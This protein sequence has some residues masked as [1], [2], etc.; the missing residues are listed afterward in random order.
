MRKLICS[1]LTC[2][3]IAFGARAQELNCNVVINDQQIQA[4]D[5]T[6][7]KEMKT[8][9]TTFMNTRRWTPDAFTAEERIKCNMI[10]T[11]TQSPS[12]GRYSATVQ[13]QS[14]RPIYGTGYETVL[15]NY[16]DKDWDFEY[17]IAQP[18]DFNENVFTSNLT[19]LLSFYAYMIIGYD[20][21]SF[22]KLGGKPFFTMAQTIANNAQQ[23]GGRGWTAFENNQNRYN[24]LENIMNPLM[25]P[26]REGIYTYHR[27]GLDVFAK[28]PEKL[29]ES[30]LELLTKIKA[31]RAQRPMSVLINSFF[32]TKANEMISIYA[33]AEPQQKQ[34]AVNLL[35][36]LDPTKTDQYQKIMK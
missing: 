26:F 21:D 29:R 36:Q 4:T 24:L 18:M 3:V 27:Q 13:I 12:I 6:I 20:Y 31:I 15:F 28:E 10:I 30:T 14:A 5:R 8:S 19:S 34:N 11:L 25:L 33:Q 9:I 23:T 2:L 22:S 32:D 1:L 35:S 7:F 16:I 17:A